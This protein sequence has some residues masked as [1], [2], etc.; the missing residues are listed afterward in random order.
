L[1]ALAAGLAFGVMPVSVASAG[2]GTGLSIG[3]GTDTDRNRARTLPLRNELGTR[4]NARRAAA[5]QAPLAG[6]ALEDA[7]DDALE[8]LR[9]HIELLGGLANCQIEDEFGAAAGDTWEEMLAD[10]R[11]CVISGATYR[12]ACRTDG[13]ATDEGDRININ[14]DILPFD[15]KHKT[16]WDLLLAQPSVSSSA[17]TLFEE[18]HHAQQAWDWPARGDRS[19]ESLVRQRLRAVCNEQDVDDLQLEA[20]CDALDAIENL[21]N[22]DPAGATTSFGMKIAECLDAVEDDPKTKGVDERQQALDAVKGGLLGRK[23]F[24]GGTGDA[25]MNGELDDGE[26]LNGDGRIDRLGTRACYNAGK[27]AYQAWLASPMGAGDTDDL[28]DALRAIRWATAIP[29]QLGPVAA[30]APVPREREPGQIFR[31]GSGGVISQFVA[32]D[33]DDHE[34]QTQLFGGVQD[35]LLIPPGLSGP[36]VLLAGGSIEPGIGGLF[37]YTDVDQDGAFDQFTEVQVLP[38]IIGAGVVGLVLPPGAPLVDLIVVLRND[39]LFF[40]N[41]DIVAHSV[42]DIN[43]DM[44]P[45][46]LGPPL[47][48][49]MLGQL[50]PLWFGPA[51]GGFGQELFAGPGRAD[52]TVGDLDALL[53]STPL[54]GQAVYLDEVQPFPP[55]PVGFVLPG[56]TFAVIGAPPGMNVELY[57][58]DPLGLPPVFTPDGIPLQPP[59][60]QGQAGLDS[61][62]FIDIPP[63][64]DGEVLVARVQETGALSVDIPIG[65]PGPV[66]C[67]AADLAEQF[68]VLDLSD[69]NAFINGFVGGD[70]IGDIDGNGVFDLT[71]V[72]LFISAFVDGCPA[73]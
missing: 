19:T 54:G 68:G 39:P 9:C 15:Q 17:L 37:A 7:K 67:N 36:P 44:I 31:R 21:E 4:I 41:A 43:G 64:L 33:C 56:D 72:N 3:D 55:F 58:V 45:D 66:P 23:A 60:S 48:P 30:G 32:T 61:R 42:L 25:N 40:P 35:M 46:Q 18:I 20:T 38:P 5:G 26:D 62:A 53:L 24:T 16:L 34:L 65:L 11:V 22:G 8:A 51:P 47:G 27:A 59:I 73:G 14:L 29:G 57:L 1:V 28:N 10:G 12:G 63:L 52:G 50:D 70:P 69:V 6:A 49:P 71:D 2:F 13:V